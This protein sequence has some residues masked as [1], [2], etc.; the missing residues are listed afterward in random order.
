VAALAEVSGI[1]IVGHV[2]TA[3]EASQAIGRLKP[4]VVI[5]DICMLGGSG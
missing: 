4:D 1:E 3:A 2:G 5:L